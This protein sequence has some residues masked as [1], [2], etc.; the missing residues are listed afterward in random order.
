MGLI[1]ILKKK[2]N[3]EEQEM[4]KGN[5]LTQMADLCHDDNNDTNF[6]T[7]LAVLKKTEAW[8]P[9]METEIGAMPYILESADGTQFYPV[10]SEENQIPKEYAE[11]LTWAQVSFDASAR[12]I[13]ESTEV[14]NMLLNAFT[15][16]V[17]IPEESIRVLM[18]ENASE[19]AVKNDDLKLFAIEADA[20]SEAIREKANAYFSGRND[21]KKAYFAKLLNGVEMS[22][23]F[24]ADVD[25]DAQ[26]MFKELFE[27]IGQADISMPIDYTV[28]PTLK[29]QLDKIGC[30]PFFE[31]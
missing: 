28:Y 11:S 9:M 17:V 3:E 10:F 6:I 30:A 18:N 14:S 24:V 2:K 15:K 13:M 1:D 5:Q 25:G 31:K 27:T 12:Y 19:H 8:V 26:G 7:L 21:V 29:E 20:E 22:Y 16:S 4:P 23:V